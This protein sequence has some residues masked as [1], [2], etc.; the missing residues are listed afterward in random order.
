MRQ[1]HNN[2]LIR[3]FHNDLENIVFEPLS[4]PVRARPGDV[5]RTLI[6][7]YELGSQDISNLRPCVLPVENPTVT[8]IADRVPVLNSIGTVR[9]QISEDFVHFRLKLNEFSSGAHRQFS[10]KVEGSNNEAIA[11]F[12]YSGNSVSELM[13][14]LSQSI[15][16][17]PYTIAR[18]KT[19]GSIIDVYLMRT[20]RFNIGSPLNVVLGTVSETNLNTPSITA[21]FLT[22]YLK[23]ANKDYLMVILGTV[24]EGN[25]FSYDGI[26]YTAKKGDTGD[27]VVNFF[28][29]GEIFNRLDSDPATLVYA[30]GSRKIIN[31][32]LPF[33]TKV[34]DGSSG[35]E[36]HYRIE[37]SGTYLPGNILTVFTNS[38]TITYT[39]APGDTISSIEAILNPDS[40][41]FDVTTG[42]EVQV[43]SAPG[44]QTIN[45]DNIVQFFLST[46]ATYPAQNMD[47]YGVV[48][49][50]D[51]VKGNEFSI[52]DP[53][54][55][56]FKKIVAKSTDANLSI[57][58][59]FSGQ[60]GS[61]FVFERPVATAPV[62]FSAIPGYKY[63]EEDL[64]AIS[65]ISQPTHFHPDQVVMEIIVPDKTTLPHGE[66]IL[67]MRDS[68][69][70]TIK[71]ISS[72]LLIDSHT[73]T[74]LI[75]SSNTSHVYGFDFS[76][77]GLVQRY[78]AEIAAKVAEPM[79]EVKSAVN[80][81]G[82]AKDVDVKIDFVSKF[83]SMPVGQN[84]GRSLV[85]MLKNNFV[86]VDGDRVR[87]DEVTFA[88]SSQYAKQVELSGTFVYLDQRADNYER[89]IFPKIFEGSNAVVSVEYAFGLRLFLRNPTFTKEVIGET[90]VPADGYYLE[91]ISEAP[92][93]GF[94]RILVR[95]QLN[96]LVEMEADKELSHRSIPFRIQPGGKV[97]IEL[98]E[99]TEINSTGFEPIEAVDV[100]VVY[101][102]E[103]GEYEGSGFDD[104]FDGGFD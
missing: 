57:G 71:A 23:G 47:Q 2:S 85:Y 84:L 60:P 91:T 34:L 92:A 50:S 97:K 3:F 98:I 96:V 59:F 74:S 11:T 8:P 6:N 27:T 93:K 40:G 62:Q 24:V 20:S 30:P 72:K 76:E 14:Q 73:R 49:G 83:T 104:G 99:V 10:L 37:L 69:T 54:N 70:G 36:D 1:I 38:R 32:N 53:D 9:R 89:N 33:I 82:E 78:R 95:D 55:D 7:K 51:V 29:G 28:T 61:Y 77:A 45:N 68:S 65:V 42:T 5:L 18:T 13:S 67:A 46:Q 58:E 101:D 17:T 56:Y 87:A 41:F 75:E 44:S 79:T 39:V 35:G 4:D 90:D 80:V 19:N 94:V 12:G 16:S 15:E 102:P 52:S 48:I 43:R 66:Y 103:T 100:E 31:S 26:S 88:T 22:T 63:T 64:M 81:N 21:T 86:R 25:I